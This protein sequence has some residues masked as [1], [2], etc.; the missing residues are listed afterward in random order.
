M[1]IL[2]DQGT[3]VP[4]RAV[5][6]GHAVVTVIEVGWS[7]FSN[8]ELIRQAEAAG[9][10]VLVTTDQSLR[11]QQQLD[12]RS[13][14]IVVLMAVSWPRVRQ[15]SERIAAQFADLQPGKYLEIPIP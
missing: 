1:R 6:T 14:A 7:R 11:Y 10:D 8:G 9:Y 13:L 5:L 12:G 3:P 15:H 2:F 4:L